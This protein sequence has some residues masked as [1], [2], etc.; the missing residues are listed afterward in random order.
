MFKPSF[1]FVISCRLLIQLKVSGVSRNLSSPLPMTPLNTV[2]PYKAPLKTLLPS[3][4]GASQS[5]T[6]VLQN[7]TYPFS[8]APQPLFPLPPLT[9]AHLESSPFPHTLAPLN[10][11]LTPAPPHFAPRFSSIFLALIPQPRNL[12]F[13]VISATVDKKKNN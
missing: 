7:L 10:T 6:T 9:V 12:G 2:P 3:H 4:R 13:M 11:S 8:M 1:F 5:L